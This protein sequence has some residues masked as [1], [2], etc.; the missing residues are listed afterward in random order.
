VETRKIFRAGLSGLLEAPLHV[1]RDGRGR[2]DAR[3]NRVPVAAAPG[4]GAEILDGINGKSL[5]IK[6][7]FF[8]KIFRTR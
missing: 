3:R 2:D 7:G 4:V 5:M 1:R 8:E 6:Q